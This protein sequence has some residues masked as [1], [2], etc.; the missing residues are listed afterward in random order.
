MPCHAGAGCAALGLLPVLQLLSAHTLPSQ[1]ARA[2]GLLFAVMQA[3]Q[4]AGL[5][6]HSVLFHYAAGK[7]V[8]NAPFVVGALLAL[9]ALAITFC[10]PEAATKR[11]SSARAAQPQGGV[12]KAASALPKAA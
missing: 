2:A 6:A 3:A 8:L 12:L 11:P 7:G 1:Q 10:A 5:A 9:V 4:A